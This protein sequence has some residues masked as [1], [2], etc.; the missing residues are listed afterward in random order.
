MIYVTLPYV[1]EQR[2]GIQ[3]V[4]YTKVYQKSSLF[5]MLALGMMKVY[6]F[7]NPGKILRALLK[8]HECKRETKFLHLP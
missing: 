6:R 3:L 8:I 5:S 4:T 2:V 7:E 1:M